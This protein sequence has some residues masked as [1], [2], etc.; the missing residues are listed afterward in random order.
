MTA[1]LLAA[2]ALMSLAAVFV[3]WPLWRTV[4]DDPAEAAVAPR[5][6]VAIGLGTALAF[7]TAFMYA[8]V[9]TPAALLPQP[10]TGQG[11]AGNAAGGMTP[12]Q[13][14]GMVSRLAQRLQQQ[15]DDVAGWRMLVRSYETLGR[16]P[17]A[18]DAWRRLLALTPDDPD[19]LTDY[20]VTLGMSQGQSLAGEPEEALNQALRLNPQHVQALA[21][22]GSAAYERADYPRAI[23]QWRRIL[24]N[25]PADAEV[26][27]SI[28]GQIAKAQALAARGQNGRAG[29]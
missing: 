5:R 15:P 25:V 10:S 11:P 23:A 19:L 24:E 1:F 8:M 28:E 27:A 21:L 22:S 4:P 6:G 18:V 26:R 13:I 17:Q 29:P 20:A 16:Y 3:V 7:F 2:L 12:A 14:E 9:G